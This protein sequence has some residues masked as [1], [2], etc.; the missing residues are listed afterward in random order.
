[1]KTLFICGKKESIKHVDE[2]Y[3]ELIYVDSEP[4]QMTI[5]LSAD[6]I[7][8][9]I[10]K[11][12]KEDTDAEKGLDVY[13]DCPSPY[14]VIVENLQVV[15]GEDENIVFNIVDKDDNITKGEEND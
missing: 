5:D 7:R 4:T 6:R 10:R 12:W 2:E 13:L 15:M 9:I 3:D 11:T 8:N 14:L 1:M